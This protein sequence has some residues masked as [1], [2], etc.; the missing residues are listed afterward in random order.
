MLKVFFFYSDVFEL[1]KVLGFKK[2]FVFNLPNVFQ[3][4]LTL[5]N[6]DENSFLSGD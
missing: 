2:Y 1:F 3:F 6:K 5:E 4:Y